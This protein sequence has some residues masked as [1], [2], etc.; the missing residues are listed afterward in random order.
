MICSD[1]CDRGARSADV[2]LEVL[3][4]DQLSAHAVQEPSDLDGPPVRLP[5]EVAEKLGLALHELTLGAVLDG[6]DRI[7]AT[8]STTATHLTLIWRERARPGAS[9]IGGETL[10]GEMLER[11]LAYDL[12][13]AVTVAETD[14]ERAVIIV[15][16]LPA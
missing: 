10:R 16:P 9:S 7:A 2:A 5:V 8:W 3:I 13:A 1:D 11:M 4:R 14:R 12:R 6:H 15:L